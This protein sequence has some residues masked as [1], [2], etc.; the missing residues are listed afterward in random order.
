[1]NSTSEHWREHQSKPV[2]EQCRELV[3]EQQQCSREVSG[4]EWHGR[5]RMDIFSK[6]LQGQQ[7]RYVSELHG[8]KET[9]IISAAIKIENSLGY[10]P[11]PPASYSVGHTSKR[12]EC[13]LDSVSQ[14]QGNVCINTDQKHVEDQETQRIIYANG[15]LL[16]KTKPEVQ[17]FCGKSTLTTLETMPCTPSEF[18]TDISDLITNR[19]GTSCHHNSHV[20]K[21]PS[22]EKGCL[23]SCC[24]TKVAVSTL[25]LHVEQDPRGNIAKEQNIPPV[26]S[27]LQST[28]LYK[29]DGKKTASRVIT[30]DEARSGLLKVIA[31]LESHPIMGNDYIQHLWQLLNL[32]EDYGKKMA[33]GVAMP[34]SGLKDE[35][36]A[37]DLRPKPRDILKQC[38]AEG[39][40]VNECPNKVI[41]SNTVYFTSVKRNLICKVKK[42]CRLSLKCSQAVQKHAKCRTH[43]DI[44]K[45]KCVHAKREN[46]PE[47]CVAQVTSE[48]DSES[49]DLCGAS[50]ES[51]CDSSEEQLAGHSSEG[52]DAIPIKHSLRR[53]RVKDVSSL[54]CNVCGK[55]FKKAWHLKD[56]LLIHT[57]EKPF[58]C[59]M[60][61]KGFRRQSYIKQHQML[62]TGEKPFSCTSC[63][64]SFRSTSELKQHQIVHTGEK[65]HKCDNCSA[66]FAY[67][68]GLKS[69]MRTHTDDR[70]FSCSICGVQLAH[71]GSL[72]IHTIRVH[73]KDRRFV[74]SSCGKAFATSADLKTHQKTHTGERPYVCPI[75]TR[76]FSQCGQLKTHMR[77]HTG[78]KPYLCPMCGKGFAH[79][80]SLSVH[81]RGHTGE[82]P[83]QC[84]LC[85]M[86][87]S[88]ST[89]LKKHMRM[90]NNKKLYKCAICDQ[91]FSQRNRLGKHMTAHMTAA[92]DR[93]QTGGKA[94]VQ[95]NPARDRELVQ[96]GDN[97]VNVRTQAYPNNNEQKLQV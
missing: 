31:F 53:K 4:S 46:V 26:M 20:E 60:C 17:M 74:C 90:H 94:S 13:P 22:S 85:D 1:M 30:L 19:A 67:A 23:G 76:R 2:T 86:R 82:R 65:P 68:A 83:Y 96:S 21:Q 9:E 79:T 15:R 18:K 61:G 62:H 66:R 24:E 64:K 5:E 58:K 78:E 70:P 39:E 69:H 59:D 45:S 28:K 72:K 14:R 40:P 34:L 27:S 87:C 7:N 71:P 38:V 6:R 84:A 92:G 63:N 41:N 50:E 37:S 51:R 52:S 54:R 49:H 48:E 36:D 32:I 12:G 25:P 97:F 43:R 3:S 44:I 57:G 33:T 55:L 77:T 10:L 88:D 42:A 95:R 89:N 47:H 80:S 8:V 35:D 16:T 91:S 93:H 73:T 29:D 11:K 56:H 75:C 81:V